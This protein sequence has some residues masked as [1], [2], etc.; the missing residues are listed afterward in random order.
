MSRKEEAA[1]VRRAPYKKRRSRAEAAYR[2]QE[3]KSKSAIRLRPGFYGQLQEQMKEVASFDE[4]EKLV[5]AML[6]NS[7]EEAAV[8]TCALLD[9]YALIYFEDSLKKMYLAIVYSE[10]ATHATLAF[11][12]GDYISL[13]KLAV[14]C[15]LCYDN[16]IPMEEKLRIQD[17]IACLENDGMV[18]TLQKGTKKNAQEMMH[19]RRKLRL[20]A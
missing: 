11:E 7:P 16:V 1:P 15:A 9:R 17:N 2:I 6:V 14:R 13:P 5:N 3:S 8:S 12:D 10:S 20:E 4:F 18:L 19:K